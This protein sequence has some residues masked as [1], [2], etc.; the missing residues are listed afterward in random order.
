MTHPDA[1]TLAPAAQMEKRRL[2][3]TMREAG[4]SFSEIGRALGVHYMTVSMW[5]D[6]YQTGGLDALAV[7]R[8]TVA[9]APRTGT[10]LESKTS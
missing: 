3:M 4:E 9:F 1:R 8:V 10:R 2:A 7:R 6:R 5:W